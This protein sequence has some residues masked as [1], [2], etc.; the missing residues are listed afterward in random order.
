M[1]QSQTLETDTNVNAKGKDVKYTR[2]ISEMRVKK[3]KSQHPKKSAS[4]VVTV[5]VEH[6]L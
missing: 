2:T 3:I 1:S 5:F 6:I 4:H